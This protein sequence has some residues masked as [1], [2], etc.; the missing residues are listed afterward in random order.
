MESIRI[1]QLVTVLL[2]TTFEWN[3]T[4]PVPATYLAPCTKHMDFNKVTHSDVA[5]ARTFLTKFVKKM[6]ALYGTEHMSYNVHTLQHLPDTVLSWGPLWSSSCFLFEGYN[7]TVKSLFHGTRGVPHQIVNNFVIVQG[8]SKSLASMNQG[9]PELAAFLRSLVTGYPLVP[10]ICKVHEDASEVLLKGNP[11]YCHG[12]DNDDELCFSN[13]F[14]KQF[15]DLQITSYQKVIFHGVIYESSSHMRTSRRSNSVVAY[16]PKQIGRIKR[17]LYVQHEQ[18]SS[19][20]L[21]IQPFLVAGNQIVSDAQ[22]GA[23]AD[24]ITIITEE[25]LLPPLILPVS[26]PLLKCVQIIQNN[27]HFCCILPNMI[28]LD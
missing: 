1:P 23:Q 19:V 24:H 11:T 5:I 4:S 14:H 12:I 16:G 26:F 27:V 13:Y 22:V 28:E 15:A 10:S 18:T 8:L 9:T 2:S 3:I 20:V 21:V 6:E 17:I 7:R 25:P